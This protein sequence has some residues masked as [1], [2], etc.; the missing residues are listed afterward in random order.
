MNFEKL[1]NAQIAW[2]AAQDIQDV[3]IAVFS[4]D[5]FCGKGR[6]LSSL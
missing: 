5:E 3:F 4:A 6:V 1:N 2:R